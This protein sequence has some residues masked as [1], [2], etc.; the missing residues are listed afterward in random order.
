MNV[1]PP[2]RFIFIES[3]N[4]VPPCI[5]RDAF[6]PPEQLRK[7]SNTAALALTR[8]AIGIPQD[9]LQAPEIT[10]ITQDRFAKIGEHRETRSGAPTPIKI[11]RVHEDDDFDTDRLAFILLSIL[12][13]PR[14]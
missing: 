13:E 11:V 2:G 4:P 7:T 6:F 8:M 9:A 14:T 12:Q 10:E 1:L 3:L 5:E